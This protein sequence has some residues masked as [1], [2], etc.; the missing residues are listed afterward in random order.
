MSG[1]REEA[2]WAVDD[3]AFAP[4]SLVLLPF[5][6]IATLVSALGAAI[7]TLPFPANFM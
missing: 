6:T 1:W 5:L 4:L 7:A 2:A 3:A